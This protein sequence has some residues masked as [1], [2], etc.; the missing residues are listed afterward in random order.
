MRGI[1]Q[2]RTTGEKISIGETLVIGRRADCDLV[3]DDAKISRKHAM[4]RW[5][6]NAYWLFDLGS[7]NGSYLNGRRIQAT[8][9]LAHS[10]VIRLG[11]FEFGFVSSDG[12]RPGDG[13]SNE[14][15]FSATIADIS[16]RP[17]LMFV[18]DIKGFTEL[19]EKISPD[20]LA[21]AIGSWYREC[22]QVLEGHGASI[23]KFIGDCV[24]AYWMDV[25]LESRTAA[26][27]AAQ[28]LLEVTRKI[29][30]EQKLAGEH[31]IDLEIGIG[32]HL[33]EVAHG[34][35][36]QGAFTLLGDAVNTTFRLESLTRK[37]DRDIVV[38]SDFLSGWSE[39]TANCEALG[40]HDVKGKESQLSVF[41]AD[42]WP[43]A[44][45]A[46]E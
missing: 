40:S 9:R 14:P 32:I 20:S 33:G 39:G 45:G 22:Q 23:D 7:S 12:D 34:S 41:S 4:V 2:N 19:S 37:L 6:D 8:T 30:R 27:H 25:S 36:S 10:D 1:L 38:S 3:L 21:R 24:L 31:D 44:G 13:W 46:A 35:M 26:I 28:S 11:P 43:R 17:V 16:T 42:S 18:S 29:I 15:D 5:Q